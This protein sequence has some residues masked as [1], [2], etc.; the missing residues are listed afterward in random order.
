MFILKPRFATFL[1]GVAPLISVLI[2]LSGEGLFA[3]PKFSV[4]ETKIISPEAEYFHGWPTIERLA[5]GNLMVVYSG[6]REDHV[7]PFGRIEAMISRDEGKTWSWPRVIMDSATDDRDGGLLETNKGTLLVAFFTSIAYQK[8]LAAPERRINKIFGD[9]AAAHIK[10][11]Q[12]ADA[13]LLP[14]NQKDDVGYW[15]IRSTDGGMTWSRRLAMPC[16][17]PHGP[18]QTADGRIF[19]AGADGK[20]NGAWV[21]DDDGVSWKLLSEIPGRPGEVHGLEAANGTLIVHVRDKVA[22][23]EGGKPRW[24]TTQTESE[25]GGKTWSD[26]HEIVAGFPSHLLRLKND[27]LLIT[28]GVRKEPFGVRAK[29]SQ[30][31]GKS[32]SE[33]MILTDDGAT[34]D[35]GYPSTV[36][37]DDGSLLTVWYEVP[38]D[39][40][41][42][43]IRQARWHLN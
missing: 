39:S 41:K 5:N 29:L 23:P 17:S 24:A 14:E 40:F 43:Q 37:L 31:N 34:E 4:D 42:A 10:R 8:H 3:A 6:G 12:M 11:S 2:F 36:Q 30:D 35:L 16:Y 27:D 32:W 22:P 21:S 28:Y 20:R 18:T 13:R 7:D 15:M 1:R 26:P 9:D 38:K 19:Y 25:D 33:E